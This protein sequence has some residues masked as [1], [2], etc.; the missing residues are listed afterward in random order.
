MYAKAEPETSKQKWPVRS[1]GANEAGQSKKQQVQPL[2]RAADACD[3]NEMQQAS[4]RITNALMLYIACDFVPLS[5]FESPYFKNLIAMLNPFYRIPSQIDFTERF[6]QEKFLEQKTNLLF[7]LRPIQNLCIAIDVWKSRKNNLYL[8]IVGHFMKNWTMHSVMLCCKR[9][10]D[11][12]SPQ[13]ITQKYNEVIQWFGLNAKVCGL[14]TESVANC[15]KLFSFQDNKNAFV[16]NTGLEAVQSYKPDPDIVAVN[17]VLYGLLPKMYAPCFENSLELVVRDGFFANEQLRKLVL[18]FLKRVIADRRTISTVLNEDFYQTSQNS[19][20]WN[21]ELKVVRSFLSLS[22]ETLA[23][24]DCYISNDMHELNVLKDLL[25]ILEPLEEAV[26]YCCRDKRSSVSY[27]IPCIRGLRHHFNQLQSKYNQSF[28]SD[29]RDNVEKYLGCYEQC[30]TYRIAAVLDARFKLNW[31]NNDSERDAIRLDLINEVSSLFATSS[32]VEHASGP[33][34]KRSKLFSYM[35]PVSSEY[36]IT[37]ESLQVDAEVQSYL[38][39]ACVAEDS[40]HLEFWKSH[41]HTYPN[42]SKLS[43][44]YLGIPASSQITR[45]AYCLDDEFAL[46]KCLLTERDFEAALFIKCNETL[47]SKT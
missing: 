35:M 21:Q 3:Y 22:E 4:Q 14:I 20:R 2:S 28:I 39:Q 46:D 12:H 44:K 6:L 30:D 16:L 34:E 18:S 8:G 43:E 29:L 11:E 41:K 5:T 25:G 38:E 24:F 7:E 27:V 26:D 33:S 47:F 9:L 40:N 31:C 17:P 10:S 19:K 23:M 15:T 45:D 13:K 36:Q 42:L 1:S 32:Q 37:S